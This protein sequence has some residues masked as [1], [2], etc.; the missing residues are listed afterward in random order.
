MIEIIIFK[1]KIKTLISNNQIIITKI[2]SKIFHFNNGLN[3]KF[4]SLM[5]KI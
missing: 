2:N 3:N 1:T 4:N 5:I